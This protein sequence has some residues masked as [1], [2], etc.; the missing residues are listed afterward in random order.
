MAVC[1]PFHEFSVSSE[2]VGIVTWVLHAYPDEENLLAEEVGVEPTRHFLS[3]SLV[4]KTRCPT[5]D[6]ALPAKTAAAGTC[7]FLSL[8]NIAVWKIYVNHHSLVVVAPGELHAIKIL[9]QFNGLIATYSQ[10]VPILN[11]R[12]FGV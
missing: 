5:G 6:I 11:N 2:D 3:A 12:K 9:E 1:E 7:L 8:A 4:L 10:V